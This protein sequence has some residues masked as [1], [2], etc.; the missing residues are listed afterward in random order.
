MALGRQSNVHHPDLWESV[1]LDTGEEILHYE[2][3]SDA[4]VD[5]RFGEAEGF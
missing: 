1:D 3:L 5:G 4:E 2:D